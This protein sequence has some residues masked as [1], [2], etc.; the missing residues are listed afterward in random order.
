VGKVAIRNRLKEIRHDHRMDQTQFAEFL[1]VNR[2]LY[3]RWERQQT[4]PN[5]EWIL[6]IA[7]KVNKSVEDIFYLDESD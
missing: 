6:K 3:N 1:G 7:Q 5:P 4:Q 2:S